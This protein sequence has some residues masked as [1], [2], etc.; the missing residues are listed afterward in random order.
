MTQTQHSLERNGIAMAVALALCLGGAG[1]A[2]LLKQAPVAKAYFAIDPGQPEPA[3]PAGA[4]ASSQATR[5]VLRVR[6]LRVSP[7][8]DAVPFVYRTGPA[9]FD[10]DYYNNFIAPPAS[11][12]TGS[13]IQWLAR[14]LPMTICDTSSNLPADLTLEGNMTGLYIDSTTTP[15]KAVVA[16]RFFLTRDH[17]GDVQLLFQ[18]AYEASVPVRARSPAGFVGAWGE[19]YHRVLVQL[20]ADVSG[21]VRHDGRGN[22]SH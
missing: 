17:N 7:P 22:S 15:P 21:F 4:Q 5:Q 18:K 16:G 9:Q 12:L 10:T 19:A 1:C 20:T 8:Y 2:G 13:L 3:R 6:A 14:A 11:L